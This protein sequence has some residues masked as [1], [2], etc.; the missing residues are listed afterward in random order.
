MEFSV[1][2]PARLPVAYLSGV[3]LCCVHPVV[4][5]CVALCC[6]LLSVVSS[7]CVALRC[8]AICFLLCRAVVFLLHCV[9]LC[10]NLL[11]VFWTC[12]VA[13]RCVVF[14][15]MS[16]LVLFRCVVF[17]L[18]CCVLF[19]VFCHWFSVGFR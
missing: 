13:L 16:Y 3:L 9:A 8:V 1:D 12:C 19:V 2:R 18:P 5:S 6:D 11:C 15:H 4:L 7:G 14:M 17:S 10:C